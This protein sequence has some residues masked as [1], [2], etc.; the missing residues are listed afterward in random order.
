MDGGAWR[1]PVHRVAELDTTEYASSFSA[2]IGEKEIK[3]YENIQRTSMSIY[4]YNLDGIMEF[5]RSLPCPGVIGRY[6]DFIPNLGAE[7]VNCRVTVTIKWSAPIW[8]LC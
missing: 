4:I 8:L 3:C 6:L 1:A 7:H 2:Y 5:W